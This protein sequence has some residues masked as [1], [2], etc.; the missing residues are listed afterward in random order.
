MAAAAQDSLRGVITMKQQEIPVIDIAQISAPRTLDELDAACRE[1]GFFQIV[2]H[3]ID[4]QVLD[5]MLAHAGE[6][7]ELPIEQKR[8]ISRTEENSWGFYDRELTKNTLDWK[9]IFDYGPE[10][11]ETRRPQWPAALPRFRTGVLE[12]YAAC[13][14]L[15]FR[16]LIAMAT[17]LGVKPNR[18]LEGFLPQHS[19]FLRLNYYPP[20]PRPERPAGISTPSAGHLGLNHHTD[21]GALT[22]LLQ[23]DQ[24]GLEVFREGEW[25]LVAPKR[26]ALV[27]NVGDV[28]QVWSND[29]YKAALHRVLANTEA[30]R[31]SVP[32]FF[33]PAYSTNY[34]PLPATTDRVTPAHYRT[35][36]WGE[37]YAK[38]SAGDYA[39]IGEEVQISHY[40]I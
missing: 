37:F 30:E 18:L 23:D 4:E 17:N 20:C 35:I 10:E 29:R 22:I 36:N 24:P 13:E 2:N 1:W 9:Q 39:D 27:V 8:A 21:A 11:G 19:S 28:A 25:H 6:F 5:R 3:G 12:Y 15:A 31:F 26:G 16:L 38:R 40:G 34:A 33:C 14:G 7:F 32:F